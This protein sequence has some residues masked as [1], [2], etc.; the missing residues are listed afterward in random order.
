MAFLFFAQRGK[1]APNAEVTRMMKT[2][3]M[4]RLSAAAL[5]L[6][7]HFKDGTDYARVLGKSSAF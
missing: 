7:A 5:D 3:A 1:Q 2:E 6:F 4:R